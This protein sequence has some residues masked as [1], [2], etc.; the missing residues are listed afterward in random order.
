MMPGTA[1]G[2]ACDNAFVQRTTEVRA[3]CIVSLEA[4]SI[5][6][7]EDAVLIDN[8]SEDSTVGRCLDFDPLDQI[9][10]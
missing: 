7:D 6:P 4:I 5:S 2:R 1:E 3:V 10:A 9:E 8:A